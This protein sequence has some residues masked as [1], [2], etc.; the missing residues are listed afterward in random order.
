[1]KNKKRAFTLIE[2]LVVIAIIA[3]LAAMLMPALSKAREYAKGSSCQSNMKQIGV[4]HNLYSQDWKDLLMPAFYA[5]TQNTWAYPGEK[6]HKMYFTS[7]S[8]VKWKRDLG[9]LG[10]PG[11]A[12]NVIASNG[13]GNRWYTYLAN[14]DILGTKNLKPMLA[15]KIKKPSMEIIKIEQL[16]TKTQ[17]VFNKAEANNRFGRMHGDMGNVI[18]ADGHVQRVKDILDEN[19][20]EYS[21]GNW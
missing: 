6:I 7:I 13:Y 15:G 10:C 2:L 12:D 16:D 4:V 5:G 11:R 8:N 20:P 17:K 14:T 9:G 21:L 3:I 19:L 1:M 18:F